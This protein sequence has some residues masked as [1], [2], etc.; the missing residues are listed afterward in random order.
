MSSKVKPRVLLL[1]PGRTSSRA[2]LGD[3]EVWFS[4]TMGAE[5]VPVELHEGETPPPAKNFDAVVMTGSPL[6]VTQRTDWMDAA[7]NYLVEAA[8]RGTRVLGV[9]FGH[10]LL[11]WRHGA[12]VVKNPHG[13]EL[14]TVTVELTKAG[15]ASP[16]F[17]G[18]PVRFEVQATHEDVVEQA[19]APMNVLARN[20]MAAVQAFQVG[21]RSFGV[22]F[23]PEMDATSIQFCIDSKDTK[24]GDRQKAVARETP[25]GERLLRR[26]LEL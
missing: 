15:R 5:M 24:A 20:A 2:V 6:S 11:A 9:C 7:S 25:F 21:P 13:R 12:E 22:Q 17:E 1:K 18:F 16:L 23:H 14:G 8:D 19:D 3:Y 4:R 10:Q 26:F